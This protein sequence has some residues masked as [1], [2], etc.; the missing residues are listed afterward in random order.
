MLPPTELLL[1]GLFPPLAVFRRL[2]LMAPPIN[3]LKGNEVA[4]EDG[5]KDEGDCELELLVTD[6][7]PLSRL[8][9]AGIEP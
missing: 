3:W 6:P 7:D 9:V 1:K 5:G 4:D 2:G 8:P